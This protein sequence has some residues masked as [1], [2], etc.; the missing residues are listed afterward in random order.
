MTRNVIYATAALILLALVVRGFKDAGAA[1]ARAEIAEARAD[2]LFV[3]AL[4]SERA[5]IEELKTR[6][7][8]LLR[9]A[10]ERDSAVARADRAARARPA[11]VERIIEVAGDSA[12]VVR[13]VTE[14]EALHVQEVSALRLALAAADSTAAGL[15]EII[16]LQ[17]RV[18]GDLHTALTAARE[19]ARLWERTT[20]P[21]LFGLVPMQ[22][23]TA[24][25]AGAGTVAALVVYAVLK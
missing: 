22:P 17:D 8:E 23:T 3:H 21:K 10:E 15:R 12:E 14:L 20:H 6:D 24:Y 11:V 1:D 5:L 9:F 16:A 13:V 25:M 2:S 19:E 4:E 7:T 18:N